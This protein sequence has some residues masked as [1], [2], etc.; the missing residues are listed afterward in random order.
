VEFLARGD[1]DVARE[2]V[3]TV[4]LTR[5][6]RLG[7]SLVGKVQRLALTLRRAGPFGAAAQDL[8]EPDEAEILDGLTRVRPVYSALLDEPRGTGERSFRS[9]ADIARAT[10]AVER[11]AAAQAM[12]AG[13]GVRAQ[14]LVALGPAEAASA[15]RVDLDT[16]V[17]AR[18]VL[19][20]RL[21]DG[22]VTGRGGARS[23]P[24]PDQPMAIEPLDPRDVRAF[25]ALLDVTAE[26]SMKLPETLK[27]KAKAILDAVSP[28]RLAGAAAAVADR[29][30]GGLAPLEP[31]LVRKTP[32]KRPRGR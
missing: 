28:G 8:A 19:V 13:L 7:V 1:D 11:A 26:G 27:K 9:L 2:A 25:E 4:P 15:A 6:H 22:R 16:G 32:A 18:T 21:L 31:V 23:S 29:W 10:A 14:D 12:L 5:L 30:I 24:A 17:L 3:R 20:R